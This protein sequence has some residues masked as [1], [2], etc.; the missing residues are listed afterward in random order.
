MVRA[1]RLGR[2]LLVLVL[3]GCSAASN[4]TPSASPSESSAASLAVRPSPSPTP[5]SY[6]SAEK[7]GE[8]GHDGPPLITVPAAIAVDYTVK[9]RCDFEFNVENAH[10]KPAGPHLALSVTGAE[11]TGTWA[12]RLTPGDYYIYPNEAV[13]CTYSFNIRADA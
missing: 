7:L 5:Q 2:L 8:G 3:T 11:V 12:L 13:G 6:W 10:S 4:Q 9:G 1:V